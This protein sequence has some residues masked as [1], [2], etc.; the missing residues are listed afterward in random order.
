MFGK[1]EIMWTDVVNAYVNN[2]RDVKTDPK[3]PKGAN[4]TTNPKGIWFYVYAEN[5]NIYIESARNHSNSSRI[6]GRRKLEN[7]KFDAM[8]LLYKRRK[9]VR[10]YHKKQQVPHTIKFIG[11]AYSLTWVYKYTEVI[12]EY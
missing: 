11:T 1:K 12:Y 10:Q 4:Y 6:S 5:G 2:A 7:E 8:L 3:P 9:K